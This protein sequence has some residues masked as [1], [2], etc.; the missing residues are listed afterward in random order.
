MTDMSSARAQTPISAAPPPR[1]R[2]MAVR[3]HSRLHEIPLFTSVSVH[4]DAFA[5]TDEPRT[6]LSPGLDSS[7][8]LVQV[9]LRR[10][11]ADLCPA[12]QRIAHTQRSYARCYLVHEFVVDRLMHVHACRIGADLAL[13]E[14]VGRHG[15]TN[16]LLPVAIVEYNERTLAAQLKG[17]ALQGGGCRG[18]HALADWHGA[19]EADF[20][21]TRVL[22]KGLPRASIAKEHI[23]QA[24]GRATLDHQLRHSQRRPRRQL[25]R[26]VHHRIAAGQ[27]HRHLPT[28]NLHRVIPG[29][30]ASDHPQRLPNAQPKRGPGHEVAVVG[31]MQRRWRLACEEFDRIDRRWNVHRAR[32]VH[33]LAHI[34]SLQRRHRLAFLA[35]PL[36]NLAQDPG[37]LC[38]GSR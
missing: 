27:S 2:T 14:E 37:P 19:R 25:A 16:G 10:E 29:T 4:V 15:S 6:S 20:G 21:H 22:A 32:L 36:R 3:K 26:L 17:D 38:S 9:G 8:H 1:T 35:Q 28:C 12:D 31:A 24:L 13:G 5:P 30:D 7:L 18:H 11:R 34:L 23:E 33:G